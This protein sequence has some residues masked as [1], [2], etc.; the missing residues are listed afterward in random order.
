MTEARRIYQDQF[1]F[2]KHPALRGF[3]QAKLVCHQINA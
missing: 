1:E 3:S 2:T